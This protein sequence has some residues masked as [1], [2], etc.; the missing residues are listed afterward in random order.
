M[1][2]VTA[3]QHMIYLRTHL[4]F[5][6]ILGLDNLNR[7]GVLLPGFEEEVLDFCDL[8]RHDATEVESCKD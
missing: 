4:E 3:L 2:R 8:A 7:L 5:D 6:L 1:L